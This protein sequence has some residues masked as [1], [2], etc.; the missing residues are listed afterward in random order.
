MGLADTVR[1][2]VAVANA[3]TAGLQVNVSHY[4]AGTP[5]EA[6][7][8]P[9]PA[10]PT[11]RPALVTRKQKMV[12]TS[13][14]QNVLSTAEVVFLDPAVVINE[15]DKIVLPDGTTGP[16][17]NTVGFLDQGTNRPYLTQVYL[18]ETR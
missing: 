3:A 13:T 2:A 10:L 8:V 11:A 1:G 5:D 6:G 4:A 12:T 14:G 7:N 9:Y 18:G 17:L 15:L 16:I